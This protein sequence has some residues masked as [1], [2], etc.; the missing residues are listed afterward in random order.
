MQATDVVAG[1]ALALGLFNL[2]V[3]ARERRAMRRVSGHVTFAARYRTS[4]DRPWVLNAADVTV[5][6]GSAH[7]VCLQHALVTS[8]SGHGV[9]ID[10]LFGLPHDL[11]AASAATC[12]VPEDRFAALDSFEDPPQHVEVVVEVSH[13]RHR[14]TWHSNTV[15]RWPAPGTGR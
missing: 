14:L 8:P 2:G 13:G 9:V 5:R 15:E 11:A 3:E 4:V 7:T 6:N 10:D 1:T 12:T